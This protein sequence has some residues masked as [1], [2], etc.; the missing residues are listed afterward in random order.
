MLMEDL[1]GKTPLHY[2]IATKCSKQT[3]NALLNATK[4]ARS[5]LHT[6]Y[7][8][9]RKYDD[10]GC[11]FEN[12]TIYDTLSGYAI[13]S[14]TIVSRSKLFDK[15]DNDVDVETDRDDDSDIDDT[16]RFSEFEIDKSKS[17]S[18]L[19]PTAE[20]K[21]TATSTGRSIDKR[22]KRNRG[23]QF[24]FD[25]II[26][27]LLKNVCSRC[28]EKGAKFELSPVEVLIDLFESYNREVYA[29]NNKGCRSG[30]GESPEQYDTMTL[31][32]C[33]FT[34]LLDKLGIRVVD[35]VV[36]ELFR[37][38][39]SEKSEIDVRWAL[40]RKYHKRVWQIEEHK[41][42]AREKKILWEVRASSRN[43][44]YED[45]MDSG[46]K[47]GGD[48]CKGYAG[49]SMRGGSKDDSDEGSIVFS[50]DDEMGDAYSDD[51]Y[52][53]DS[54]GLGT[55][56]GR[57]EG[58]KG[59]SGEHHRIQTRSP[60]GVKRKAPQILTQEDKLFGLNV[61]KL[62][63]DIRSGSVFLENTKAVSCT[64]DSSGET[65]TQGNL[66]VNAVEPEAA[67]RE[68]SQDV[69]YAIL[70]AVSATF[71]KDAAARSKPGSTPSS[72]RN[73]RSKLHSKT[74]LDN[75]N[76]G[77]RFCSFPK[78]ICKSLLD[79]LQYQVMNAQDC[80][81]RTA[82]MIASALGYKEHVEL[83]LACRYNTGSTAGSVVNLSAIT[84]EG[85]TA[86]S[87]SSTQSISA[88]LQQ[89]LV[90]WLNE[91]KSPVLPPYGTSSLEGTTTS[92]LSARIRGG[93]D[94]DKTR[95]LMQLIPQLEQ[96]RSSNWQYARFPLTWAV[97]NGLPEAVEHLLAEGASQST[98]VL[99]PTA[100]GA[101]GW[102]TSTHRA[103]KSMKNSAGV[104][105]VCL[106]NEVDAMGRTAMHEC[107]TLVGPTSPSDA[108]AAIALTI[109]EQLYK[110]GADLNAKTISGKTPL[111]DIFCNSGNGATKQTRSELCLDGERVMQHR[112][113]LLRAML[114]WG[115]DPCIADSHSCMAPIHYSA[116]NDMF[117][118]CMLEFLRFG[119]D[120]NR[121]DEK[122]KLVSPIYLTTKMGHNCLHIACSQGCPKLVKLLCRWDVEAEIVHRIYYRAPKC[123]GRNSEKIS[124][125]PGHFLDDMPRLSSGIPVNTSASQ[126][127]L[128]MRDV[129]NKLPKHLLNNKSVTV[130]HLDTLWLACYLGNPSR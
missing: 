76:S 114:Q 20:P 14:P 93:D 26:P 88:V 69:G 78:C 37:R 59:Y 30:R 35:E 10:H 54:K 52:V 29:L 96:L 56:R 36:N 39:M 75:T 67:S 81:D 127:L 108:H 126:S 3:L 82:L 18:M 5:Q 7:P 84:R 8:K 66:G 42:M 63:H 118:N 32:R 121:V 17:S 83:L 123:H 43:G 27:W 107:M 112:R 111:H 79:K 62:I 71:H 122:E 117:E 51:D 68:E 46:A 85:H 89:R 13:V 74:T 110:K 55:H 28:A 48:D 113:I 58:E 57:S 4:Q 95:A 100:S 94:S 50:D 2:A 104:A 22:S 87:L 109:A 70:S 11:V 80:Y 105:R 102:S 98:R 15:V 40:V 9:C 129:N 92:Q 60:I 90:G 103:S 86:V 53:A 119:S 44:H 12:N 33:E 1:D 125:N 6:A 34:A 91:N 23:V 61:R 65:P 19:S 124:Y 97:L 16:I 24:D 101:S 73:P 77:I 38:Y 21:R 64:P 41:R 31:M 99:G 72:P 115:A 45:D 120:I 116:R 106:V 128:S 47:G 49:G 130:A 25:I